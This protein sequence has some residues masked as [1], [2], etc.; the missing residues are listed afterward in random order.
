MTSCLS[1]KRANLPCR[2]CRRE[3]RA[4]TRAWR[5]AHPRATCVYFVFVVDENGA[6][7]A[8]PGTGVRAEPADARPP[9]E[10][11]PNPITLNSWSSQYLYLRTQHQEVRPIATDDL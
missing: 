2:Y 3:C 6:A 7:G 8:G 11:L 5:L 4:Y 1:P 9:R 10:V